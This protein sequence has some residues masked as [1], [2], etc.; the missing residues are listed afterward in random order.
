MN[1]DMHTRVTICIVLL[2]VSSILFFVFYSRALS[3]SVRRMWHPIFFFAYS[4][5]GFVIPAWLLLDGA[6][7]S[8]TISV[9]AMMILL[10]LAV[11]YYLGFSFCDQCGITISPRGKSITAVFDTMALTQCP[12]CGAEIQKQ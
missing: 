4:I 12:N 3:V 1:P 9:F 10:L 11:L 5:V 8:M 6:H 7:A 2:A